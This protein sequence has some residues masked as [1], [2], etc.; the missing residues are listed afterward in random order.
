VA[1]VAGS[2]KTLAGPAPC[3]NCPADTF[4][5]T[6]GKQTA[7]CEACGPQSQSLAGSDEATDCRCNV[8]Y[9]GLDGGTCAMCGTGRYKSA[10]GSARCLDCEENRFQPLLAQTSV[11]ACQLCGANSLSARGNSLQAGCQCAPGYTG[12][13]GGTCEACYMGEYK[14]ERGPQACTLCPTETYSSG[15]AQTAVDTCEACPQSSIAAEGSTART[16]CRCGPGFQVEQAGLPTSS[17]VACA[18]GVCSNC[19]AGEY[20]AGHNN[21]SG[22][23]TCLPCA[24]GFAAAAQGYC[25]ACP[26]NATAPRGSAVL[27]DCLCD[28]GYTGPNGGTCVFCPPG[29]FKPQFG[30]MSCTACPRDTFSPRTAVEF[31]SDCASCMPNTESAPGSDSRD[32]C[33]CS[34][35]W[36]SMVAGVDGELCA[37]CAAGTFKNATGHAACEACP[38]NTYGN[39]SNSTSVDACTP[40]YNNSYAPAGSDSQEDCSCLGGYE[41]QADAPALIV[42]TPF[43]RRRA[44]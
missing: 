9:S 43:D 31:Q 32:D 29:K 10:V 42:G 16:D 21:E 14:Q 4:S 36:T 26:I 3:D 5:T 41:R 1:C 25:D 40:C 30:A 37:G 12:P 7:G 11:A 35:G 18:G 8:G 23:W 44:V 6:V 38:V 34:A 20:A 24:S 2:Y 13:N 39:V 17:C 33:K 19:S 27:E 15:L 22:A 28:P